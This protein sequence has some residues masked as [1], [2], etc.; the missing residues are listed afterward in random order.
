[1]ENLVIGEVKWGELISQFEDNFK[2]EEVENL[3][4]SGLNILEIRDYKSDSSEV[5]LQVTEL[6]FSHGTYNRDGSV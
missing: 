5:N 1:M 2:A 3:V 4:S 6:N